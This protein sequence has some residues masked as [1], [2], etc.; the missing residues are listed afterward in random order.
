MLAKLLFTATVPAF[1]RT[2]SALVGTAFPLQL[3]A[4]NQLVVLAPPSHVIVSACAAGTK[5]VEANNAAR[6]VLNGKKDMEITQRD[7]QK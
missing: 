5:Q 2:S 7:K 1:K 6:N 3:L 4:S